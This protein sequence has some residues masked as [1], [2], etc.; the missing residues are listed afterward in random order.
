MKVAR[1]LRVYNIFLAER[2]TWEDWVTCDHAEIS[3]LT[4]KIS[5][6]EAE[7]DRVVYELFGLAEEE[8]TLL[9]GAI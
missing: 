5:R 1:R 6:A 9:E 4:A 7:I 3:R 8:V 2:S